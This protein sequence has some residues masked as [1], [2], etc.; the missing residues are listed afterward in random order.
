MKLDVKAFKPERGEPLNMKPLLD[1]KVMVH[2]TKEGKDRIV[3]MTETGDLIKKSLLAKTENDISGFIPM[4]KTECLIL[5]EDGVILRVKLKDG[6]EVAK[7]EVPR[8]KQIVDGLKIDDDFIL[9]LD[10]GRGKLYSYDLKKKEKKIILKK[11]KRP[12]SIDKADTDYGTFY[13]LTEQKAH[14]V[15]VYDEDGKRITRIGGRGPEDGKLDHPGSARF[16]PDNTI[17]VSDFWN[18]RISRFNIHG[19]FLEHLLTPKH[20]IMYPGRLAVQHPNIWVAY[21]DERYDDE[22]DDDDEDDEVINEEDDDNDDDDDDEDDEDQ[23][24]NIKCFQIYK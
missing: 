6:K 3:I 5:H 20:K 17:V 13:I 9:L 2:Y 15:N 10:F 12:M 22:N 8:V 21:E 23:I 11:L 14:R 19:K 7:Y 1:G 18:R 16:L 24:V 4:S